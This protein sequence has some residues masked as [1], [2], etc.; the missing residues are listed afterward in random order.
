MA[1]QSNVV[2]TGSVS[3]LEE[4]CLQN[5]SLANSSYLLNLFNTL[6]QREE[7]V[8][9]APKSLSGKTLGITTAQVSTLGM[10]LGG[11]IP[12]AILAAGIGVWLY[13]RYK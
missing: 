6:T 5:S 10:V 13:R 1:K 2:V 11:V 12:L 3:M 9:I 8:T 7:T 4:V